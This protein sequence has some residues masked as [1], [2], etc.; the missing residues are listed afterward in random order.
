MDS[1]LDL[2]TSKK[3]VN[4]ELTLKHRSGRPVEVLENVFL[5]ELGKEATIQGTV[6]DVTAMRQAEL[7]Q[8]T[9][10][11]SYR[12]L[13]EHMRD[14]VLVVQDDS[15]QYAN[16]AAERLFGTS[17]LGLE[18]LD[19]VHSEQHKAVLGVIDQLDGSKDHEMLSIALS[20]G[21][22]KNVILS[23]TRVIHD[24]RGAVQITLQ[25]EGESQAL[26]RE[27]MRLQIAEELNTVLKNEI[28]E[29]QRTQEALNNSRRF[30]RSLVDSSLDMIMAADPD[31]RITEYN[32]AASLRFGYEAQ[33]VLGVETNMLYSDP[34]EYVRIQKELLKYGSFTGEVKNVTKSG[35]QFT[36]FL[37]ASRM[38][39]EDGKLLGAMGVSR[40]ITRMKQDQEALKQ[41]RNG[42]GTCSRAPPI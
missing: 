13:V 20:G 34:E 27:Q 32:P 10:V 28:S 38:F 7:E 5:D 14:A 39:D 16:P 30:A 22:D 4:Y 15:I 18:L 29:H 21:R 3:L 9:L 25:Q 42:T 24:G 35:E 8:A 31:G 2:K 23:A 11:T 37:A 41:A 19:L 1:I 26:L 6:I 33:E 17:L 12:S 36:S 40:D